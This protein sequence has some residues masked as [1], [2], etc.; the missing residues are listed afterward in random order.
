MWMIFILFFNKTGF[1]KLLIDAI[2]FEYCLI[3]K[4]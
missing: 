2:D 4:R 3:I 1:N